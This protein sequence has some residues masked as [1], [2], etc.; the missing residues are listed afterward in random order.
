M[1]ATPYTMR[2]PTNNAS[3]N[4][5]LL[6]A[7]SITMAFGGQKVLNSVNFRID[8]SDIILLKGENG[9]GK[10]TLLNI[11]G[12]YLEPLAGS[13]EY[14]TDSALAYRFPRRWW[15]NLNPFN[16]FLPEMVAGEGVGR[17]WQDD[18]LFSTQTIGENLVAAF[19]NRQGESPLRALFNWQSIVSH[20]QQNLKRARHLLDAFGIADQEH[21]L[22][23]K[24]SLGQARRA[25]IARALAGGARLLLLDEPFAGLDA[26]G[27]VSVLQQLQVIKEA[28][29]S[30]VI[31]E[32]PLNESHL[33]T[34]VTKD[35][36][37]KEGTLHIEPRTK[38][39]QSSTGSWEKRIAAS[40][41]SPDLEEQITVSLPRGGQL[42]RSRSQTAN[43]GKPVLEVRNIVVQ[44]GL[45]TVIGQDDF[46]VVSGLS[47]SLCEGEVCV[48]L[49]PNGWGKTTLF[50][51][52]LGFVPLASGEILIDGRR[53]DG[54]PPWVRSKYGL[55]GLAA[56][57]PIFSNLTIDEMT[58]LANPS[59][60]VL[61]ASRN[62]IKGSSLSGGEKKMLGHELMQDGRVALYDEPFSSL[63]SDN[64]RK[65]ATIMSQHNYGCRLHFEP[66]QHLHFEA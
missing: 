34:L 29:C 65:A 54:A 17:T 2:V 40:S 52:L 32:H 25:A 28:Q 1:F 61:S 20:E 19:P 23:T 22:A 13:L 57:R 47:F 6:R 31:V 15:S 39:I 55:R 27:I 9:S 59:S 8:E 62:S 5:F 63:D 24:V 30:M 43:I 10:T 48:L 4:D 26:K 44:H 18:R 12:G 50:R 45:R 56:D 33:R 51:A 35:W 38:P 53:I 37:L 36:T 46:G 49:A 64:L 16:D 3:R 58:S 21:S 7:T 66:I 60:A 42:I 41:R 14:S 11:I